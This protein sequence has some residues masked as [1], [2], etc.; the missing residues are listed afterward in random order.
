VGS[1]LLG[2]L[3]LLGG[4]RHLGLSSLGQSRSGLTLRVLQ[5]TF[6][7]LSDY[8]T[9]EHVHQKA[10]VSSKFGSSSC[11]DVSGPKRLGCPGS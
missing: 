1:L 5:D 7:I 6:W 11:I 3:S 9:V 10:K 4:S 8:V 2:G